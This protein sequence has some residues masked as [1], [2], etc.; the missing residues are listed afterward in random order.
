[1][2]IF[3]L[4]EVQ[5]YLWVCGW[6]RDI[7]GSGGGRLFRYR[8]SK[9]LRSSCLMTSCL[10]CVTQN[11]DACCAASD[12]LAETLE[13]TKHAIERVVWTSERPDIAWLHGVR[14]RTG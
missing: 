1:M 14:L 3:G 5:G 9:T 10:V 6:L 13:H 8:T 2:D 12:K 11:Q 4:S 7:F